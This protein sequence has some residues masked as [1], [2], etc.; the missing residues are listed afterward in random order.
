MIIVN[1][2]VLILIKL[3]TI[4]LHYEIYSD[5][6]TYVKVFN[7]LKKSSI[8]IL[9]SNQNILSFKLFGYRHLTTENKSVDSLFVKGG[10]LNI[11][12]TDDYIKLDIEKKSIKYFYFFKLLA[13]GI[14]L[15]SLDLKVCASIRYNNPPPAHASLASQARLASLAGEARGGG[16]GASLFLILKEMCIKLK[17]S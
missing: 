4:Y 2:I 6:E 5:I 15:L 13:L 1:T 9:I 7:F 8:F 17:H 12:S 3:F 10:P 14:Y 11:R 16:L